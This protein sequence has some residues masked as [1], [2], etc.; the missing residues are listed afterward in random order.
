VSAVPVSLQARGGWRV[1][2]SLTVVAALVLVAI[3]VGPP[4]AWRRLQARDGS[5]AA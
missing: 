3:V 5:G 2:D 4:L 1:E